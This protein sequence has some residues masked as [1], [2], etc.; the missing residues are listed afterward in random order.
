MES[1][2]EMS[3]NATADGM[4]DFYNGLYQIAKSIEVDNLT[5]QQIRLRIRDSL[6]LHRNSLPELNQNK[7]EEV[8]ERL[9]NEMERQ[10]DLAT[11]EFSTWVTSAQTNLPTV[12]VRRGGRL[13]I[14]RQEVNAGLFELGWRGLVDS[15]RNVNATMT[16]VRNAIPDLNDDER[17]FFD[18]LYAQQPRFAVSQFCSC[19]IGMTS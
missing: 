4:T 13:P 18:S 17:R 2:R 7:L 6:L 16:T 8:N 11:D 12:M 3:S 10:F 9:F 15:A 19:S 14:T 1:I 5:T